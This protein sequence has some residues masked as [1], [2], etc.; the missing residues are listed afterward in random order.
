LR[1]E[2]FDFRIIR[3]VLSAVCRRIYASGSRIIVR[4]DFRRRVEDSVNFMELYLGYYTGSS[5][6][7]GRFGRI[8]WS[9]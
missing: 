1:K 9:G 2:A 6:G 5:M 8:G 3:V 7:I 4:V